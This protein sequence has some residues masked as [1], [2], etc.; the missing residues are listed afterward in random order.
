MSCQSLNIMAGFPVC[1][2]LPS[3]HLFQLQKT[4]L[5]IDIYSSTQTLTKNIFC[6]TL[7]K[8]MAD[9]D[10]WSGL[11]NSLCGRMAIIKMN[12]LSRVNFVSSK[13]TLPLPPQYWS[14]NYNQ[15]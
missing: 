12:I 8:V 14:K 2:M 11:P 6:N 4:Y 7:N 1:V 15:K 9:L 5:G 3:L 10:R 13:L